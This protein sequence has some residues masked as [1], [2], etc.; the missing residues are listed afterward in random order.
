LSDL[1]HG[2][3]EDAERQKVFYQWYNYVHHFPV[4]FIRDTYRKIFIGNE[5]IRRTLI[6]GGRRIGIQDYPASVP[7]WAL[8]GTEDQIT[9]PLQATGHM[10]LIESLAPE[11]K[12]TLIC[13]GG[14][15]GLFRSKRVLKDYYSQIVTFLLEKSDKRKH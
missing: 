13:E 10:D 5:L 8:G 9:P 4:S 15:M 14:H 3:A 11:D 12:L 7:V 6:I 1:K 2:N